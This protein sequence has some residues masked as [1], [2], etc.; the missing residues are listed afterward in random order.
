MMPTDGG[1]PFIGDGGPTR[2]DLVYVVRTVV[3]GDTAVF[4]RQLQ[5]CRPAIISE[6]GASVLSSHDAESLDTFGRESAF[7]RHPA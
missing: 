3:Y 1:M 6:A 7:G 5:A 2:R 4:T